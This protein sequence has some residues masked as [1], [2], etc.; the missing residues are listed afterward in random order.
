MDYILTV[1]VSIS[2]G[3]AQ[4]VSAFPVLMDNRV[5]IAVG[6]ILFV[7]LVNLR[8]VKEF[9]PSPPISL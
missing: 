4:I 5:V 6:L 1:A 8:G 7:M 2:S 9:L 3:V